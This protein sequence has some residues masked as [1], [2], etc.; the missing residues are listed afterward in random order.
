MKKREKIMKDLATKSKIILL[1]IMTT[2][3]SVTINSFRSYE[4]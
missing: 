4:S 3:S 1:I 2:L